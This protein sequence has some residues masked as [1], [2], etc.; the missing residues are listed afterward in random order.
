MGRPCG[1]PT[2]LPEVHCP[3]LS[4]SWA[5]A[6]SKT[7]PC[8]STWTP[9]WSTGAR[10]PMVRVI[11]KVWDLFAFIVVPEHRLDSVNG[12]SH[13]LL[14]ATENLKG[15]H[16]VK[17]EKP[18]GVMNASPHELHS[19]AHRLPL[20]RAAAGIILSFPA[21]S[22][23]ASPW[24]ILSVCFFHPVQTRSFIVVCLFVC[25]F[26]TAQWQPTLWISDCWIKSHS[27][28]YFIQNTS[29]KFAPVIMTNLSLNNCE[30]CS[31]EKDCCATTIN[32]T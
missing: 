17:T 6:R 22:F 21:F 8:L 30:D 24:W 18:L 12:I 31:H 2:S 20:N 14:R 4:T 10:K 9:R 28:A 16:A 25:V 23:S 1:P 13:G 27:Q 3:P 26:L 15:F 29:G 7:T 5:A 32:I 11:E 19:C